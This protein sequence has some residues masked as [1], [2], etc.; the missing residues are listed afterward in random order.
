[1]L[2]EV[3]LTLYISLFDQIFVKMVMSVLILYSIRICLHNYGLIKVKQNLNI[4]IFDL[5]ENSFRK[6][7]LPCF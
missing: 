5:M 2:Y 6:L 3:C 7:A 4:V 1:M